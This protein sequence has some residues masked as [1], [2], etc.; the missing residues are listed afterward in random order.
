V[1]IERHSLTAQLALIACA[2][3][4]PVP[5]GLPLPCPRILCEGHLASLGCPSLLLA[6]L[7]P[8]FFVISVLQSLGA[9]FA[10]HLT[11]CFE[12]YEVACS[13]LQSEVP[14]HAQETPKVS[15]VSDREWCTTRRFQTR[16]QRDWSVLPDLHGLGYIESQH[17][18]DVIIRIPG[19]LNEE[20]NV[21]VSRTQ[22]TKV[23]A[24][25]FP[26]TDNQCFL[27]VFVL[28]LSSPVHL[29]RKG[30]TDGTTII[31]KSSG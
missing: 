14:L 1:N 12:L 13:D 25:H 29:L 3:E 15:S 9:G 16:E 30:K 28:L 5:K 18:G 6:H 27:V 17:V 22:V 19:V 2:K 23:W 10:E 24:I 31:E 7:G 21:N 11:E 26:R 4:H 8:A 20:R